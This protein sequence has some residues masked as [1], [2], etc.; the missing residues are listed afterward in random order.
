VWYVRRHFHPKKKLFTGY[1][2]PP[3]WVYAMEKMPTTGYPQEKPRKEKNATKLTSQAIIDYKP[4]NIAFMT[5]V[6]N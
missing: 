6:L 4:M 5:L 2:F 3:L 1:F